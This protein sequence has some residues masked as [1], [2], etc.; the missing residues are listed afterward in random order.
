MWPTL[1]LIS[2]AAVSLQPRRP[3]GHG[4]RKALAFARDIVRLRG[5]GHSL[6]AIRDALADAG[7]IVSISTIHREVQRREA[8]PALALPA[9]TSPI[10]RLHLSN[11]TSVGVTTAREAP[12]AVVTS[13]PGKTI[14][15][16]FMRNRISN[17]LLRK[18]PTR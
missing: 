2:S 6:A 15:E 9:G 3:P 14:A 11:A 13:L 1:A 17:P 7:V 12:G 4:N 18:E 5:E 8:A 10:P 16:E